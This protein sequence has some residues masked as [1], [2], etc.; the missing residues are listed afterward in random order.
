[1]KH[2]IP[3]GIHA[4]QIRHIIGVNHVSFG[5]AHL[6]AALQKPRMAEYLLRKRQIERHKEDGP[7][8]RDK[9]FDGT[10]K[11]TGVTEE[12]DADLKAIVTGA[13]DK[14]TAKME[15]LRVVDAITP[16]FQAESLQAAMRRL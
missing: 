11:S 8:N 3:G 14:V 6:I 15:K 1:M 13:R 9:Y 7:V 16:R 12:V 4:E 10:V 2:K 5:F